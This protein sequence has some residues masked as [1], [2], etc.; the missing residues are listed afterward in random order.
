[1]QEPTDSVKPVNSIIYS[2]HIQKF[3][4]LPL[5]NANPEDVFVI[6]EMLLVMVAAAQLSWI[7]I[8]NSSIIQFV[9]SS[10]SVDVITIRV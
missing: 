3:F 7:V 4:S 1:M 5:V 9:A 10:E 2:S 6:P 8:K